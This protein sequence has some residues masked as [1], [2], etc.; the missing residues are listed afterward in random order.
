MVGE[1]GLILD[2]K[3]A[4][5]LLLVPTFGSGRIE[6]DGVELDERGFLYDYA[7]YD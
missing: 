5:I 6:M 7:G 4:E 1:A 3:T 2:T